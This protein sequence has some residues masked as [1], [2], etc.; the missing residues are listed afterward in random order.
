[1]RDTSEHFDLQMLF[2]GLIG[3]LSN[4]DGFFELF[5]PFEE[6]LIKPVNDLP[7][8]ILIDKLDLLLLSYK[9]VKFLLVKILRK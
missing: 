7:E 5:L 1:M 3:S 6:Y 8:M 9:K 4:W 2:T